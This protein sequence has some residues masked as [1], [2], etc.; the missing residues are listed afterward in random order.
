MTMRPETHPPLGLAERRFL[1]LSGGYSR[2]VSAMK[3]LLPAVAVGLV[4]L[5]AVWPRL[6]LSLEHLRAAVPRLDLSEARDLRMVNAHYAGI[7]KRHRPFVLTAEVAR[8]TQANDLTSLEGP[9]ADITLKSGAWLALTGDT[10][11]YMSPGQ[12]LDLFGNVKLFHDRGYEL[13]TD[14]AHLDMAVGTAEGNDPVQG[15]GVFGD[16]A[17]QGFRLL[18]HGQIIIFTGKAKLHLTPR[19]TAAQ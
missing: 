12:L 14:S 11:V 7:D 6:Q 15:Q 18:D 1:R 10:G 3:L 8:Q 13:N 19:P 2:F 16:I 5:V 4:L 9:K 17:S